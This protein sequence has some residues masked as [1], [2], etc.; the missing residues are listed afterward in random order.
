MVWFCSLFVLLDEIDVYICMSLHCDRFDSHI[1]GPI[2]HLS[3]NVNGQNL[4]MEIRL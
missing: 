1:Q 4:Y 3:R 2:L